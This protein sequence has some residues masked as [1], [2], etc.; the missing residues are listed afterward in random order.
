MVMCSLLERGS[1]MA[2]TIPFKTMLIPFMVMRSRGPFMVMCMPFMNSP[3][4]TT[5]QTATNV[6]YHFGQHFR[7]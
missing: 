6:V 2:T 1:L 5:V 3:L 7:K 4:M